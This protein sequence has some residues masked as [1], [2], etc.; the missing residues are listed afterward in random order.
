MKLPVYEQGPYKIWP[1]TMFIQAK[2]CSDGPG[3]QIEVVVP[4]S[5]YVT[6]PGADAAI[7]FTTA[8][9]AKANINFLQGNL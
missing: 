6:G 5:F 7:I 4:D 9:L 8:E 2:S 3:R 1:S